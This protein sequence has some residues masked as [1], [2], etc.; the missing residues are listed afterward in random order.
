MKKT[1][2]RS[3]A[4]DDLRIVLLSTAILVIIGACWA[5]CAL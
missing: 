3:I 5:L 4:S 2:H 1:A